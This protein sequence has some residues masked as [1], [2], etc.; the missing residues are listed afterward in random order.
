MICSNCRSYVS[1]GAP[2]CANCGTPVRSAYAHTSITENT[3]MLQTKKILSGVSFL[4]SMVFLIFYILGSIVI[5]FVEDFWGYRLFELFDISV[6]TWVVVMSLV[7]MLPMILHGI[8][9]T[10]IWFS[11]RFGNGQ[12]GAGFFKAGSI[13]GIIYT[14]LSAIVYF[15][16]WALKWARKDEWSMW[17]LYLSFKDI[18]YEAILLLE[19]VIM[20][21]I[22]FATIAYYVNLL[23][24]AENVRGV[25]RGAAP[26]KPA[27]FPI[28]I[29]IM[30]AFFT[31]P[32]VIISFV[33]RAS[34]IL[35]FYLFYAV[36]LVLSAVTLGQ[37]RGV[38]QPIHT[39]GHVPT[40]AAA[41]AGRYEPVSSHMSMGYA[42]SPSMP[43]VPTGYYDDMEVTAVFCI[44][45]GRK[46]VPGTPCTCGYG[47]RMGAS[48][49]AAPSRPTASPSVSAPPRPAVTTYS[50]APET[51]KS[52]MHAPGDL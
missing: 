51:G 4:L 37:L 17:N 7:S 36:S 33:S 22:G 20:L 11:M 15:V 24:A 1:E 32:I 2:F 44:R 46:L 26:R 47:G 9:A 41:P 31:A 30:I 52:S 6:R 29:H 34:I 23:H 48:A 25:M 14:V 12:G 45:C 13:M 8:G 42:Y 27:L 21:L 5:V 38:V 3:P 35:I 10:T 19:L 16:A 39:S 43:S 28:V 50:T 18:D 49:K 40:A